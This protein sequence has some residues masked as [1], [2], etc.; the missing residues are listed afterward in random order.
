MENVV[1]MCD[2]PLAVQ[3]LLVNTK[4]PR[5]TKALVAAV[6]AKYD[7]V[8]SASDCCWLLSH[9]TC[10][11]LLLT[12]VLYHVQY[13]TIIGPVFDAIDA[14]SNQT[15]AI[16][17]DSQSAN[18]SDNYNSLKVNCWLQLFITLHLLECCTLCV[19]E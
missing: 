4:V 2:R 17:E 18:L 12:L 16:L 1:V 15:V 19:T 13:P 14:I 3:V 9:V 10:S 8:V 11:T 5:S 6:R 7:K